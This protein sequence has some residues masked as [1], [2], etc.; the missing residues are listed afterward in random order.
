MKHTLHHG[1]R[2]TSVPSCTKLFASVCAAGVYSTVPTYTFH[3]ED[4]IYASRG[5]TFQPYQ[6]SYEPYGSGRLRAGTKALSCITSG[7][8]F[9]YVQTSLGIYS[10]SILLRKDSSVGHN[11][12]SRPLSPCD[13]QNPSP[14]C[15]CKPPRFRAFAL[16]LQNKKNLGA[17]E[18]S[19]Q[20][21]IRKYLS[22]MCVGCSTSACTPPRG[23]YR[24]RK[25]L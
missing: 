9:K 10:F 14:M 18:Y 7:W 2:Q 24:Y 23:N 13:F 16:C 4:E 17:G 11:Y 21:R 5:F 1:L 3:L 6:V 19:S 15:I 22:T 12:Q 25:S 8:E 20:I